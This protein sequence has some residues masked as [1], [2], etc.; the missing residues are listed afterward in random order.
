MAA[1]D[2]AL[3]TNAM[4]VKIDK[5]DEQ[6]QRRDSHTHNKRMYSSKLAQLEYKKR[7][8]KVAGA[9]H[10]SLCE[11][12]HIKRSEQWDQ[13]MAEL[14]IETQC[15]DPLGHEYPERSFD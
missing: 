10:W 11:T 3:R 8:D 14:V 1:Q 5:Q 12:Y 2:Q 6:Q 9:V 13:H 15:Q 7:H 4:K